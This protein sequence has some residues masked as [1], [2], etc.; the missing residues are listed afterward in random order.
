MQ[1]RILLPT[2]TA[3]V[4][5]VVITMAIKEMTGFEQQFLEVGNSPLLQPDNKN[6][7]LT[8]VSFLVDFA[9]P[10]WLGP[11]GHPTA[12]RTP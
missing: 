1:R 2:S 8:C 10:S 7:S 11:H 9:H 6:T 3:T 4:H 12:G 5:V